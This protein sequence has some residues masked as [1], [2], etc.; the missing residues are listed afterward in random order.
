M[1]K[2]LHLQ[3]LW[4]LRW[5]KRFEMLPRGGSFF[6]YSHWYDKTQPLSRWRVLC[7][8]S[9][10]VFYWCSSLCVHVNRVNYGSVAGQLFHCSGL[11]TATLWCFWT[12][13]PM[14]RHSQQ[15]LLDSSQSI[16]LDPTIRTN[17]FGATLIKNAFTKMFYPGWFAQHARPLVALWHTQLKD[18][19][20]FWADWT[21][22]SCFWPSPGGTWSGSR[23]RWWATSLSP[24]TFPAS[25]WAAFI[26][27]TTS[28]EPCTKGLQRL[29][30]CH[31]RSA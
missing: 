13:L 30:T 28:P 10:G 29:R 17:Q 21:R 14:I 7:A 16:I 23:A 27:Q 15:S 4:Y 12:R 5:I 2:A 25:S 11:S 6:D 9:N 18:P 24:F 31:S 8:H 26:T 1:P 19:C 3:V 20:V 22:R